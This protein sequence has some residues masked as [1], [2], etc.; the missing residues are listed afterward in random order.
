VDSKA[1]TWAIEAKKTFE[2]YVK[3]AL[4]AGLRLENL[5][6]AVDKALQK[7]HCRMPDAVRYFNAIVRNWKESDASDEQSDDQPGVRIP[8]L[9]FAK[10]LRKNMTP[11]EGILRRELKSRELGAHFRFQS[12]VLGYIADFY[13]VSKALVVEVDGP[14]HEAER[15]RKRDEVMLEHGIKTL[16]FTNEEVT[17][18]IQSVVNEIIGHL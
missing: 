13:C 10:R 6:W 2:P 15:D 16:R 11:A 1:K 5:A 9:E 4:T 14:I 3:R 12:I 7:T 8:K 17:S 18:N